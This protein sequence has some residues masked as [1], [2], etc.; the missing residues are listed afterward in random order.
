MPA[1]AA[2]LLTTLLCV[3]QAAVPPL[4]EAYA[5]AKSQYD[6]L[7][8]VEQAAAKK[9]AEAE[10]AFRR[11]EEN[12]AQKSR[13]ETTNDQLVKS[14]RV[15]IEDE[16]EPEKAAAARRLERAQKKLADLAETQGDLEHTAQVAARQTAQ[17]RSRVAEVEAELTGMG[18]DGAGA[19]AGDG[20][21]AA[22]GGDGD[23]DAPA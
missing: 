7:Y 9:V 14:Y 1:L 17:M 22:A 23:T 2:S 8:E 11:A 12:A 20:T 10:K 16:L 15:E 13:A 4:S 5:E 18:S 3:P 6:A 19:A 21:G